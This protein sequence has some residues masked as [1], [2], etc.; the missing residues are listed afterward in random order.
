MDYFLKGIIT[1]LGINFLVHHKIGNVRVGAPSSIGS[2]IP[3]LDQL[4]YKGGMNQL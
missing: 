1:L 2:D 3:L 4:Y